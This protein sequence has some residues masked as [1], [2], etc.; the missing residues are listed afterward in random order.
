MSAISELEAVNEMLIAIGQAPVNTLTVAGIRDV[1]IARIHI[2]SVS[3]DLQS[4]GCKFNRFRETFTPDVNGHVKL[5]TDALDVDPTDPRVDATVQPDPDDN[6]I[7][8]LYDATEN[9]FVW[10]VDDLELDVIREIPFN[11]LPH[12]ARRF[13]KEWAK[14]R[15]QAGAV[16][17]TT[18]NDF[19]T[20]ETTAAQAAFNK[21]ERRKSDNNMLRGRRQFHGG[22]YRLTRR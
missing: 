14:V 1:S 21:M 2:A 4:E 7:L 17:S 20:D 11:S 9:T 10:D 12:Y 13:I 3:R 5:P 22:M 8:K 6:D 16:G 15:F 19:V 18:L